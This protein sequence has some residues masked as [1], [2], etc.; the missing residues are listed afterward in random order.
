[1]ETRRSTTPINSFSTMVGFL[2]P[3]LNT[4]FRRR[5]YVIYQKIISEESM[6]FWGLCFENAKED[7]H[8]NDETA[9]NEM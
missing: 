9:L 6:L 5:P 4:G 2:A 1:M 3:S 8:I 7:R